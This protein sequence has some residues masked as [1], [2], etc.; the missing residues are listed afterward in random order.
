MEA[1]DK[2]RNS[3]NKMVLG[4]VMTAMVI[5]FQLVGS[6]TA[7]FGPFSTAVALIPIVIGGAMCGVS[8]GAWLGFVF[9]LV[10]LLS[11]G[12]NLFLAFDV[13]GTLITVLVKGTACG[14][15]AAL[16]YKLM[17]RINKYAATLAAAIVCPVV[18]TGIFLLGGLIFFSDD[19]AMIGEA[20]GSSAVG[21][22]LFWGMAMANFLIELGSNIVLSPLVVRILQIRKKRR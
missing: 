16:T 21:F 6:L 17:E 15:C 4:A 18:N 22:A 2:R 1:L 19:A 20:I 8:V 9:G 10:V 11:G 7:F 12:A 13:P 5:I 14:L 3:I